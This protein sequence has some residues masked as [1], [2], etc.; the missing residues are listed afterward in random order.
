MVSASGAI[1]P[2]IK[3]CMELV[4]ASDTVT[5]VKTPFWIPKPPPLEPTLSKSAMGVPSSVLSQISK[6]LEIPAGEKAFA[7]V[8]DNY[9]A[10]SSVFFE[11]LRDG[12]A[13]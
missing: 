10:F 5:F 3:M 7:T 2:L 13:L 4:F 1:F 9:F 12:K 6:K 11:D 8:F